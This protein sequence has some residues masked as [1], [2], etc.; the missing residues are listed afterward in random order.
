MAL[1]AHNVASSNSVQSDGS[2]VERAPQ[3]TLTLGWWSRP[4]SV[5]KASFDCKCHHPKQ[6]QEPL[7]QNPANISL[8]GQT[9]LIINNG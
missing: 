3:P 7:T 6:Y 9:D 8:S 1:D 4:L 5:H 2:Y